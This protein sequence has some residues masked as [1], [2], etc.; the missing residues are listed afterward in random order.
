MEA[1]VLAAVA[2]GVLDACV[3]EW[4]RKQGKEPMRRLFQAGFSMVSSE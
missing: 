2:V 4:A 3:R 1:D